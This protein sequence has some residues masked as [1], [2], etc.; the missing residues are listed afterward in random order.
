MLD[1]MTGFTEN[2]NERIKTLASIVRTATT[3]L[4][5]TQIV[6]DDRMEEQELWPFAWE[7]ETNVPVEKTKKDELVKNADAQ[8][9]FLMKHFPDNGNSNNKS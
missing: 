7:K 1:A 8:A 6:I 3:K 2:E 9:E 4:W 5:N